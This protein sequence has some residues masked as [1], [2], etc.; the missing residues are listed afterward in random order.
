MTT[1]TE[2]HLFPYLPEELRFMIWTLALRPLDRPGVHIFDVVKTITQLDRVNH[3]LSRLIGPGYS[4]LY[5]GLFVPPSLLPQPAWTP[6]MD[7]SCSWV[8]SLSTYVVPGNVNLKAITPHSNASSS[9]LSNREKNQTSAQHISSTSDCGPLAR[10]HAGSSKKAFGSRKLNK[11]FTTTALYRCNNSTRRHPFTVFQGRDETSSSIDHCTRFAKGFSLLDG[12]QLPFS[13]PFPGGEVS[14][15][16][17]PNRLRGYYQPNYYRRLDKL[18]HYQDHMA[19]EWD[20]SWAFDDAAFEELK[21]GL[22]STS[23][24]R[25]RIWFVDYGLRPINKNFALSDLDVAWKKKGTSEVFEDAHGG[26][27]VEVYSSK[28]HLDLHTGERVSSETFDGTG[29]FVSTDGSLTMLK[30][31]L[32]RDLP[33]WLGRTL[34]L[35]GE[36]I[37][38]KNWAQWGILAYLPPGFEEGKQRPNASPRTRTQ[39]TVKER[40]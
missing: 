37:G 13:S 5:G 34:Q 11:P 8:S 23:L 20:P 24:Q 32:R 17:E 28:I 33:D 16:G 2:F 38:E 10:S 4:D 30:P 25:G 36:G 21:R 7:C 31:L 22:M 1:L 18:G 14:L 29:F 12:S 39:E 6:P 40:M 3:H 35:S 19:I 9:P 27:Y 26:R 15:C